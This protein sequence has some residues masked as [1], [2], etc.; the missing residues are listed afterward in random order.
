MTTLEVSLIPTLHNKY[1][2]TKKTLYVITMNGNECLGLELGGW[3][4]IHWHI[5]CSSMCKRERTLSVANKHHLFIC[6][7]I[8]SFSYME[9]YWDINQALYRWPLLKNFCCSNWKLRLK[10][11]KFRKFVEALVSSAATCLLSLIIYWAQPTP[12]SLTPWPPPTEKSGMG[13]VGHGLASNVLQ[14]NAA[15]E[16]HIKAY[17]F[18]CVQVWVY[19]YLPLVQ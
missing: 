13:T 18:W 11:H 4:F 2:R 7:Y 17:L 8:I 15:A 5:K 1:A 6:S 10:P 14:K 19:T 9:K 12:T 3:I 16:K